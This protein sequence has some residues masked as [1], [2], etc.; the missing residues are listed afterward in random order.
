M[1]LDVSERARDGRLRGGADYRWRN[2]VDTI[3]KEVR[4]AC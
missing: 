4:I 1:C 3:N 2:V